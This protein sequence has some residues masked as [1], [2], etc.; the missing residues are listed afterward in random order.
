M[1][2]SLVIGLL[3]AKQRQH[4]VLRGRHS[5]LSQTLHCVKELSSAKL[6]FLSLEEITHLVKMS[7]WNIIELPEGVALHFHG[8]RDQT[9]L[10][11]PNSVVNG[12]LARNFETL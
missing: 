8:C 7:P 10:R 6:T 12:H 9:R 5:I 4:S 1:A 3:C 2:H 11:C